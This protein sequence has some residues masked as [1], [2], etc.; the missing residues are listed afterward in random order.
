MECFRIDES[1]YTGHDL[2][3]SDQRF[4][5]A[6][7]ISISDDDAARLIREYFPKCQALELKYST[8]SRRAKN[9]PLLFSL[10]RDILTQYKCVTYICDKRYLLILI[11]LNYVVEPSYYKRGMD[12]YANGQNYVLGSILYY[13]GHALFGKKEFDRL[14]KMFQLAAKK[15]TVN[16]L[17]NLVISARES[18]WRNFEEILGPLAM[19]AT[20]ECL[21]EI[22]TSDMNTDAAL[23][24]LI[25]LI[26]RMEIMT[27]GPYHVE[28]DQSKNLCTYNSLIQRLI[29]HDQ[30]VEFCQSK[31]TSI[32]FPL[33]LA[34]V[35]QVNSKN[36]PAVQLADIMIGSA[37]ESIK[38]LTG[39]CTQ[40]QDPN[41]LLAL[42]SEHQ[43][44]HLLP[45]V[46]F[47][48]QYFFHQPSE[49]GNLIEY[50]SRNFG[51]LQSE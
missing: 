45:S 42:Y 10:Q 15:K 27:D 19:Y 21:S 6:T 47:D 16:A 22:A 24:V 35:E 43:L 9:Y 34:S 13:Y 28:H 3:N 7:A 44:I 49:S 41:T 26:S 4:Q 39:L 14:L 17:N 8:L 36:S 31:M 38:T 32:K 48:E 37:I 50:F 30:N 40:K 5:G 25:A 1:G 18:Q 12:F 23:V 20:Q 29:N 33:K 11:F 46:D 2:L 51:K